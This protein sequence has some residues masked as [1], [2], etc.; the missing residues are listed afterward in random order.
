MPEADETIIT[1][2]LVEADKAIKET[3]EFRKQVDTMKKQLRE[4]AKVTKESF[5]VV[6]KSI[7]RVKIK[8]FTKDIVKAKDE[9][10]RLQQKASKGV[11]DASEQARLD[12]YKASLRKVTQEMREF[13]EA[14]T[15]A[16]SEVKSG[17]MQAEGGIRGFISR[18][19]NLG[20]V[21]R[22]VFGTILGVTAISALRNI[23]RFVT[24]ATKQFID[25]SYNLF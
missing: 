5:D 8:D 3:K 23:I 13:R 10:G 20:N 7:S 4:T 18:I 9:I 14:S 25:F 12:K 1:R 21:S 22:F 16:L 19:T 17:S 6:S 15:R 2:F 24:E 11:L